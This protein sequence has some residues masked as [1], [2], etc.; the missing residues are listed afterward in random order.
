MAL[1]LQAEKQEKA[2][3]LDFMRAHKFYFFLLFIKCDEYKDE[4]CMLKHR[5]KKKTQGTS[6]KHKRIVT[7]HEMHLRSVLHGIDIHR[8]TKIKLFLIPACSAGLESFEELN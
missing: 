7:V 8:R 1:R 6:E 4:H 2:A 5:I 3:K